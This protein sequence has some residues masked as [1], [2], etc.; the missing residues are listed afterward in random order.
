MP[1]PDTPEN[2]KVIKITFKIYL[3]FRLSFTEVGAYFF[4][5]YFVAWTCL[6]CEQFSFVCDATN[7]ITKCTLDI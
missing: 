4:A 5:E 1:Y 7:P 2:L 3:N 6:Y